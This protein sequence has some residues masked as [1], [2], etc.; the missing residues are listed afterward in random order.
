M[1]KQ[2]GFTLI[3]MMITVAILAILIA[4]AAPAMDRFLERNRLTSHTGAMQQAL[5]YARNE[6]VAKN[7]PVAV[8]ASSDGA[9]C[10]GTWQQGWIVF[11]DGNGD[12]SLGLGDSILREWE[13]LSTNFTMTGTTVVFGTEGERTLPTGNASFN[14][15]DPEASNAADHSR[16]LQ[17][18]LVGWVTISKGAT[19]C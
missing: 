7:R 18:N 2:S 10:T 1:K 5:L 9:S 19:G 16:T 3:E 8:C 6:S 11:V 12:G 17:V 15:C 14:V 13:A 4:I